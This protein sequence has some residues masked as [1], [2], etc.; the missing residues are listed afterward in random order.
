MGTPVLCVSNGVVVNY[1]S[2]RSMALFEPHWW[3]GVAELILSLQPLSLLGVSRSYITAE[4]S[5]VYIGPCLQ[6]VWKSTA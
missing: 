6:E 3:T 2:F 1:Y 5:D 4:Y